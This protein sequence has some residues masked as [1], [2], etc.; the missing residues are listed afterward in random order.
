MTTTMTPPR[1]DIKNQTTKNKNISMFPQFV[2]NIK[3]NHIVPS[4]LGIISVFKS[5]TISVMENSNILHPQN[6]IDL[7]SF[8]LRENHA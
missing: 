6:F 1:N 4:N 7:S 5:T 3:Y 2:C 8:E